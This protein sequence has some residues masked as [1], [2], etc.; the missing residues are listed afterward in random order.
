MQIEKYVELTYEHL[1][2]QKH[3]ME[4]GYRSELH[5]I[6]TDLHQCSVEKSAEVIEYLSKMRFAFEISMNDLAQQIAYKQKQEQRVKAGE[7]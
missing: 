2:L 6:G 5:R 4:I 3:L 7:A 1:M